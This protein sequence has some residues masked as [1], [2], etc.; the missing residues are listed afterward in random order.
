MHYNLDRGIDCFDS[1]RF[2]KSS[3]KHIL[4]ENPP[5]THQYSCLV[6]LHKSYSKPM[7]SIY[8]V[9]LWFINKL[10]LLKIF[11]CANVACVNVY[12]FTKFLKSVKSSSFGQI[13]LLG[14]S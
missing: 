8:R 7:S 1:Y 5:K 9:Q 3:I 11:V 6:D 12:H 2:E 13:S 4:W 14:L 10:T